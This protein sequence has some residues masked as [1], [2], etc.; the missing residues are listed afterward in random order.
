MGHMVVHHY[1][2]LQDPI[3]HAAGAVRRLGRWNAFSCHWC[4]VRYFLADKEAG[5]RGLRRYAKRIVG[6]REKEARHRRL[7]ELGWPML[8]DI[9][10]FFFFKQK[11]AYEI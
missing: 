2:I 4:G 1:L 9:F 5:T 7:R 11:T 6:V 8:A 10:V 3:L